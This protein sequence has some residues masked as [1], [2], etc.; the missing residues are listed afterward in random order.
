MSQVFDFMMQHRDHF[1]QVAGFD[2]FDTRFLEAMLLEYTLPVVLDMLNHYQYLPE[3][4][5]VNVEHQILCDSPTA[6]SRPTCSIW[7][8]CAKP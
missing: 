6:S 8:Q 7:W 3:L 5:V 2:G 1:P 4:M